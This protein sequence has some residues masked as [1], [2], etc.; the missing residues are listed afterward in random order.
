VAQHPVERAR[1]ERLHRIEDALRVLA[2]AAR[3]GFVAN[4][5]ARTQRRRQR[6][7]SDQRHQHGGG[8][9]D[10]EFAEEL[11]DE[12]AHEQNRNEHGDERE[13]HREQGEADFARAAESRA[14]R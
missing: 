2:E 3:L 12:P 11:L 13:V 1:V 7:R 9:R 4:E 5:P 6:Q 14:Q 8:E 10:G